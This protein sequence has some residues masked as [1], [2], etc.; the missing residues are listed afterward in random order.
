MVSKL[1]NSAVCLMAAS[2]T[3]C[4]SFDASHFK[5]DAASGASGKARVVD[6]AQLGTNAP[7]G[8]ECQPVVQANG[9]EVAPL[10]AAALPVLAKLA[11]DLYI[12]KQA[13]DLQALKEASQASY[14]GR[15]VLSADQLAAMVDSRH[16]IA[17]VRE[18]KGSNVPDFLAVLQLQPIKGEKGTEAFAFQ[19]L[20]VSAKNSVAL[21]KQSPTPQ[22]TAS[23]AIALKG[24]GKQQGNGLPGFAP[25]GEA[26][27]TVPKLTIG[28]KP[29]TECEPSGCAVS[30]PIPLTITKQ[31]VV[32]TVS[33]AEKGEIGIDFDAAENEL[34]AIKAAL[35]PL[36]ADAIKTKLEK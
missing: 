15:L 8:L 35:G 18:P 6:Y 2:L 1:M 4:A 7:S 11:F 19:P 3:A 13:R 27:V 34:K 29:S 20:Y 5:A 26:A 16:C 21:T 36:I 28:V 30:E 10:I 23:I 25:T 17:I 12:D 14:S 22:V 9:A 31:P 24:I 32:L 33:V